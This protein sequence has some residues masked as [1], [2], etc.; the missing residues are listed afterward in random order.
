VVE[1]A[2]GADLARRMFYYGSPRMSYSRKRAADAAHHHVGFVDLERWFRCRECMRGRRRCRCSDRGSQRKAHRVDRAGLGCI[3]TQMHNA[4]Q[5]GVGWTIGAGSVDCHS[6]K[7]VNIISDNPPVSHT[8]L[9]S[10]RGQAG[11]GNVPLCIEH[12][13]TRR[14]ARRLFGLTL[15]K[16]SGAVMRIARRGRRV[17]HQGRG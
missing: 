14:G 5:Q 7:N 3:G 2:P 17:D 13:T 15:Q 11:A 8:V 6:S 9:T 12:R 4:R 1:F 10:A 16:H